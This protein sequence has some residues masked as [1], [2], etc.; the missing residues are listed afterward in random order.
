MERLGEVEA[1]IRDCLSKSDL[2]SINY[3]LQHL[4]DTPRKGLGK[5]DLRSIMQ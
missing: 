1:R 4:D 2:D 5:E 3:K